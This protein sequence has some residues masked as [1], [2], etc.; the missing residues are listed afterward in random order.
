MVVPIAAANELATFLSC[1]L[2]S[3][4]RRALVTESAT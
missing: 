4:S 1:S 2:V 3:G